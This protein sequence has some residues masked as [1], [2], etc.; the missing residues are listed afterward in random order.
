MQK[1][2]FAVAKN[3]STVAKN[4]PALSQ[5]TPN[6][7]R[8]KKPPNQPTVAKNPGYRRKKPEARVLSRWVSLP[9]KWNFHERSCVAP[10][11]DTDHTTQKLKIIFFNE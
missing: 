4:P 7:N 6:T 11:G 1:N 10:F 5:K 9:K 8:R 2:P 3:P